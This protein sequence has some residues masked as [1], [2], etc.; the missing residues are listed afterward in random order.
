MPTRRY[1]II[2][3]PAA[4][5]AL[6]SGLTTAALSEHFERAGLAF[7][8][9]DD[10]QT[11]MS[12]RLARALA[13]PAD[14]VVAGGGDG[15]V[16]AVAAALIGS[17]K[18]LAVLPLGTLN[19]LA[20]DLGLALDLSAAIA[21]LEQLEPRAIDVAEVNGR[22]FLHNV[23]VGLIPGIAIGRELI[24]GH[25]GLR[26]KIRFIRFMWRRMTYAHRIA[27]ALRSDK[28]ATR[29]ELVQTLVVANNSY[30]QRIGTFMARH[31]LDRGT[32]TAYLIRS[33]R[34]RDALRLAFAM[35]AGRWRGDQVM[36]FEKVKELS[37][38]SKRK[39]VLVTMDGEVTRL[40]TPLNFRVYPRS[41]QVLAPPQAVPDSV[42]VAAPPAAIVEA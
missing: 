39:R 27:L 12:E 35:V 28:S 26:T 9:D 32:M 42:P 2:F 29:I 16:L 19:G 11:E 14:V 24:R 18:L 13:G 20:R 30:D 38:A 25:T 21:Q 17:D 10:D 15:T 41:L 22:P 40:T 1:H 34:M 5:T 37:V 8:I 33:L 23:I 4:G 3:N 36:E 6:N 31:R 7:D